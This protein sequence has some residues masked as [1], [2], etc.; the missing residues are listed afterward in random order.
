MYFIP[1]NY[2]DTIA[3]MAK[4]FKDRDALSKNN[5]IKISPVEWSSMGFYGCP[6]E[7][8]P[9]KYPFIVRKDEKYW[10]NQEEL[11]IYYKKKKRNLLYFFLFMILIAILGITLPLLLA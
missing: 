8:I 11:S 5:A 10:F 2:K 7:E 3:E 1:V 6:V 4:F 9:K